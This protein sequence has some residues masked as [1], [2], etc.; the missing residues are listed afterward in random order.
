MA[1]CARKAAVRGGRA[2]LK[3]GVEL[4]AL[5]PGSADVGQFQAVNAPLREVVAAGNHQRRRVKLAD[6]GHVPADLQAFGL[7]KQHLECGGRWRPHVQHGGRSWRR[8]DSGSRTAD[9]GSGL[10]QLLG[11]GQ[12]ML[13]PAC[14]RNRQ[15]DGQGP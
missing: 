2:N 8:Q 4:N 15:G 6:A 7:G 11:R 9:P 3:G 12:V 5:A 10:K 1:L 14:P 13:H